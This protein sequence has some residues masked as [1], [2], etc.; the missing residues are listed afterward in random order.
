MHNQLAS[1]VSLAKTYRLGLDRSKELTSLP[2]ATLELLLS[3][4]IELAEGGDQTARKIE[5]SSASFV[6]GRI[7]AFEER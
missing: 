7:K 4:F 3:T 1:V 6:A 2:T 5:S